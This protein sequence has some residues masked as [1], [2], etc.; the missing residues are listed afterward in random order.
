MIIILN[1]PPNCGKDTIANI[2]KGRNYFAKTEFKKTMFNAALGLSGLS[3]SEFLLRY[4]NRDLK[5]VAWN[6]LGGLSCREFMIHISEDVMKPLFGKDVFGKR[7]SSI[8]KEFEKSGFNNIV[9]SDGGF[10]DEVKALHDSGLHV[11]VVRLHRDNCD[12]NGDSRSYLYPDFCDSLDIKLIDG[13]PQIAVNSI[14]DKVK[15]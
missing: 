3:E 4:N 2:L 5:E 12:F 11:L 14:M 13:Y 1:G 7:A 15:K 10:I 6:K 8:C 9:F